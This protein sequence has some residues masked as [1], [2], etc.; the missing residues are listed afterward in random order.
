MA[1]KYCPK[2]GSIISTN[3]IPNFCYYGCGSLADQPVLPPFHSAAE[4]E[5]VIEEAKREFE[6]RKKIQPE[7]IKIEPGRLQMRLF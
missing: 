4:R 6:A 2:C 3:G 7:A 5:A 1:S